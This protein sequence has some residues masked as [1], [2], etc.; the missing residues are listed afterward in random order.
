ML[1]LLIRHAEPYSISTAC[2][3]STDIPYVARRSATAAC[4]VLDLSLAED[5]HL[6]LGY[7]SAHHRMHWDTGLEDEI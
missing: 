4:I 5:E 3:W 1:R 6:P 2:R 7:H